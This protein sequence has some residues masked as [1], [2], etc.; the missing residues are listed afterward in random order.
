MRLK[1]LGNG[2][3]KTYGLPQH[4]KDLIRSLPEN[5]RYF[6][7]DVVATWCVE[8]NA[9]RSIVTKYN[10]QIEFPLSLGYA[11]SFMYLT[12][13]APEFLVKSVYKT[14]CLHLHP[15][16]GGDEDRFKQLQECYQIIMQQW[17]YEP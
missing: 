3:Y 12:T 13:E 2:F 16:K 7:K 14:L 8:E 1:S 15:D 5:M 17:R 9:L 4:I 6:D 11:Y 10:L